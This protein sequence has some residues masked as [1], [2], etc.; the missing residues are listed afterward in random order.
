MKY[1]YYNNYNQLSITKYQLSITKYQ[2][3]N[4]NLLHIY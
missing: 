4:T 2:L 1:I 3:P